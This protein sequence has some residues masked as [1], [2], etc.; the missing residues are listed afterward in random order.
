M[1]IAFDFI[2]DDFER[3][4]AAYAERCVKNRANI[5]KRYSKQI[6][7]LRIESIR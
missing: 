1:T 3:A 4:K 6:V 7:R 5:E 2:A